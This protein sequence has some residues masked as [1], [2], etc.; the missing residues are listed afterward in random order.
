MQMF[1]NVRNVE[2]TITLKWSPLEAAKIKLT[3]S[4][5][6]YMT[7]LQAGEREKN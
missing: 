1:C 7:S 5:N 6:R 3:N 2:K 4:P